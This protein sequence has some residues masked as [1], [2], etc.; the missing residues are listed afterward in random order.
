VGG[1]ALAELDPPVS[2]S[3]SAPAQSIARTGM[4][5][6][7]VVCA[8][9]MEIEY[10]RIGSGRPVLVVV[11]DARRPSAIEALAHRLAPFGRVVVPLAPAPEGDAARV[12]WLADFLDGVGVSAPRLLVIGGTP[13]AAVEMAR[14]IAV[15]DDDLVWLA[16]DAVDGVAAVLRF[17]A[18]A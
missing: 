16:L 5:V 3:G 12:A 14:A 6:R 1:R 13:A 7:A 11:R 15:T 17:V 10:L 2:A 18:P 8:G 4:P 9:G